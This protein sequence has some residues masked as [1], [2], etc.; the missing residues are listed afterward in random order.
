LVAKRLQLLHQLVPQA[1][2][3]T[4]LVNPSNGPVAE[5][6]LRDAQEAAR[7]L[8]LQVQV[9]NASTS[10]EVDAAFA[11]LARER[12]DALFVAGDAFFTS[13][14]TQ[15]ANFTARERIPA[16]YGQRDYVAAGGLMRYGTNIAD[17][18]HQVGVYSGS[19]LKGAKPA[20][21]PVVQPTR[22]QFAINLQTARLL[23]IAV[24]PALLAIADEAIE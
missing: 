24:S 5:T 1:V 11:T 18:Y 21:L 4:V 10:G 7:T 8:G 22:F 3:V 23:G 15:L 6:T 14:R 2:R 16:A 19:I 20:D 9:L 17:S 12:P 13:R